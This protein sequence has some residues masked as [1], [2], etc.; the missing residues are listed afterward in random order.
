L[1]QRFSRRWLL[2]LFAIVLVALAV[3]IAAA[4]AQNSGPSVACP[5]NC[6]VTFD[7]PSLFQPASGETAEIR[8][9]FTFI[10]VAAGIVF[11]LVEGM[12][13]F[14]VLRFRNRPPETAMQF[15]GNTR[16]EIA[17][18]AAPGIILAVVLGFTLR[19]MANVR[20]VTSENVLH[21][22]VI[23]HQWWWEFRYPELGIVT[24]NE[25]VV[26]VNTVI[27]VSVESVDVEHSLWAPELF[28]KVDAVPGYT[29]RVRFLPTEVRND[30]YAGQC[31]EYCGEQH[32][33]MRFGVVVRSEADF[34]AWA[35]HQ[36]S[37]PGPV[38]GAAAAGQELFLASA[39]IGCHAVQGTTAVG[40]IGP[41]LTHLASRS[42]LAGGI[43]SNTPENLR[44][45]VHDAPGIKSGVAMPSFKD[46][47]TDQQL[48]EL[49]AYLSSLK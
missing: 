37:E 4:I 32:A 49:V 12:L 42:F 23:G 6:M 40:A 8:A 14:T 9:L 39:C 13:L 20:A 17:W 3:P 28:G 2:V 7:T 38:D 25:L 47:F 19:T 24:A 18:T 10:L 27:E 16:L 33:Q 22:T 45:W 1:K 48:D 29:N 30:Y 5:P 15:H 21:V 11:V 43:L 31:T 34:Q 41:N 46:Q 35:A 26:P 44:A 36:Q